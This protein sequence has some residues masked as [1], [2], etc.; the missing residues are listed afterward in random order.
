MNAMGWYVLALTP[1]AIFI[2]VRYVGERPVQRAAE[3]IGFKAAAKV[4]AQNPFIRRIVI[5][6]L[7]IHIPGAIRASVF[8][9]YV[10]AIIEMPE[11]SAIIMLSYFAAGP[12]AVPLWIKVS[13]HLS[14]HKAAALGVFLHVAVTVSYLLPGKGDALLFASL[15]FMSGIV[16]AGVPFLIRSMVADIVDY[17]RLQTGQDRAGL[18][19]ATVTTTMKVGGAL[20]IGLGYPVLALIGFDPSGPNEQAQLDGLRYVYAFIPA[21]SELLV[22]VLLYRYPLGETMQKQLREQLAERDAQT[23]AG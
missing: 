12:I 4:L 18:F 11:W 1:I 10:S 21:V 5:A 22:V 23:N 9:F 17:D 7:F 14:K 19:Y 13:K 8:I 2:A 20:G 6:D 16:Y 3:P 15:F